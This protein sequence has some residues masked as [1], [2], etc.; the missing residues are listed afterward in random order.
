MD[1]RES[2]T[3]DT[4]ERVRDCTEDPGLDSVGDDSVQVLD[5]EQVLVGEGVFTG[6]HDKTDND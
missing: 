5:E 3:G 4:E 6:E 2:Y 1:D